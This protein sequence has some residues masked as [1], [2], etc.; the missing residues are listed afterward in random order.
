MFVVFDS[1]DYRVVHAI[2]IESVAVEAMAR[3]AQWVA[4]RRVN[5][6]QV[7]ASEDAR[8][9]TKGLQAAQDFI[10]EHRT[11]GRLGQ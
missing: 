4:G 11:F 7:L 6:R 8:D 3:D 1:V 5:V 9:L 2:E 10:D